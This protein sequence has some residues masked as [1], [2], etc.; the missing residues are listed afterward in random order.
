MQ[1]RRRLY[2]CRRKSES[3][4][5]Q[6]EGAAER[7]A[8]LLFHKPQRLSPSCADPNLNFQ[9][10]SAAPTQPPPRHALWRRF[11]VL[12]SG[13]PGCPPIAL[14]NHPT[15]GSAR[16]ELARGSL[17]PWLPNRTRQLAF[18]APNLGFP[19]DTTPTLEHWPTSASFQRRSLEP[20][21]RKMK[22]LARG[23][24]LGFGKTASFA[25]GAPGS[26]KLHPLAK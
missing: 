18:R 24:A 19:G 9:S 6:A 20:S 5:R 1:L 12:G 2:F 15:S 14:P 4:G 7:A 23:A 10:N 11:L 25:S 26:S 22:C 13:C 8:W 17:A 3:R 16:P 21:N